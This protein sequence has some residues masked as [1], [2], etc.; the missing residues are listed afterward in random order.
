M[1]TQ[2]YHRGLS[3]SRYL[4]LD[5]TNVPTADYNWTINLTTTGTITGGIISIPGFTAGSIIF[6]DGTNLAEDNA[7]LFWDNTNKRLGIGTSSPGSLLH[8]NTATT[9]SVT[10]LTLE[11][12]VN[13]ANEY[14]EILFKVT[15]GLN[16]GAIRSHLGAIDDSYMTF[17][18]TTDGGTLVQHMTIQH[19]G[20]VG[21]GTTSPQRELHVVS[22]G[23][24]EIRI[25]GSSGGV[26][27][28]YDGATALA[29]IYSESANKNL[30][31][32]TNGA[33][34]QM[35]ILSNGNVGIGTAGPAVK[36]EIET[37]SADSVQEGLRIYNP[38]TGTSA[39]TSISF[40]QGSADTER[41][42]IESVWN[43]GDSKQDLVFYAGTAGA[44]SE[45]M[46]IEGSGNVGIGTTT[47]SQKLDVAGAI[48]ASGAIY[49]NRAD[50][51]AFYTISGGIYA[52]GLVDNYFAGNVGI[53]TTTPA[54]SALLDLTS[55]TGALLLTRMTTAQKNA[56]TAV[57]GMIVYDS[58]LNKFQGYE[59]GGWANLI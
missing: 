9:T 27:E 16:Y 3:D 12:D 13:N 14:N 59:A 18:T 26:L 29:S 51:F 11:S 58:D 33:T 50:R 38:N 48:K 49:G 55:T 19:D 20:K 47:P 56:L 23:W 24:A 31:F 17:A 7:N 6:S 10:L 36:L 30:I 1:V 21:I 45:L 40:F 43:T 57:N 52:A 4:K 34:E 53:G 35:R 8:L 42:R 41:G 46:R 28:L 37:A 2:R 5:G 44:I 39:G 25:D 32:R 22:T 15:G 54:T